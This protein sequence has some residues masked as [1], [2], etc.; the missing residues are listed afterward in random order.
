MTAR[1]QWSY[2]VRTAAGSMLRAPFVH[3][4]AVA[5]LTLSLMGLGISH[6]VLAQL[7][8]LM[9][10]LGGEV[11]F[12]VYLSHEATDA[13]VRELEQSL[14]TRTQ[15][16][17][18]RVSPAQALTRLE[19][20]LGKDGHILAS[21]E[22][23]PLPPSLELRV[24]AAGRDAASLST[25]AER[26]RAL[27]FVSDVDY[28]AQA[29]ERMVMIARAVR[30]AGF[31]ALALVFI[32]AMIVVAATLQLAIFSRRE[33]I[34][35]QKLVGGTDW[36]VRMPFLLEGIFQGALAFAL[37]FG[38]LYALGRWVELQGEGG[39]GALLLHGQLVTS[40]PSLAGQLALAGVGLGL[41][42]SFIA[43]RRF[44]RV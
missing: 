27:S 9:G 4:A 6:M 18:E 31:V 21:M 34:E 35:I 32:T 43:V 8:S 13:Q 7:D 30:L 20:W 44:L 36:F 38:A 25:L 17:V 3:F 22:S 23:N 40:W 26:T 16:T 24:P 10:S 33:E 14:V 37:S 19:H 42:G 41:S 5:A 1:A 28:G 29:L 39:W 2:F 11:E 12:T 15:G